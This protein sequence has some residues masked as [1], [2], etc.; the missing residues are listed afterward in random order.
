MKLRSDAQGIQAMIA[1][2][3]RVKTETPAILYAAAERIGEKTAKDLSAAAPKG[4][5]GAPPQGDR[6]GRLADSFKST[7]SQASG[8]ARITVRTEQP[9]KL[10]YVTGGTGVYAGRGPIRPKFKKALW[11]PSAPYP[12]RIVKGQR[13]N[14]FVKPVIQGRRD[15]IR[16]EMNTAAR[17]MA[18]ML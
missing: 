7:A 12:M 6:P 15:V 13:P 4:Q 14:N 16:R 1:R 3:R 18:G 10:R 11:W 2:I 9:T 17:E 8:G 5:G